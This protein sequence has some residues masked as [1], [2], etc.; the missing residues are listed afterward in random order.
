MM[1][2]HGC[3]RFGEER[4]CLCVC[5]MIPYAILSW[6]SANV[7]SFQRCVCISLVNSMYYH[8][9]VLSSRLFVSD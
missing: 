8:L 9:R 3:S 5:T 1:P 7:M 4:I 6:M 2:F